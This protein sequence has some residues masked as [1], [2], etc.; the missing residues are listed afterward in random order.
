MRR[1]CRQCRQCSAGS[2]GGWRWGTEQWAK[3]RDT[4]HAAHLTRREPAE[5]DPLE[6]NDLGATL[7]TAGEGGRW[8][9]RQQRCL[10]ARRQIRSW[11]GTPCGET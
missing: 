5:A 4:V 8:V 7:L 9:T 6:T 3:E 1:Q 2:A 11:R 10:V